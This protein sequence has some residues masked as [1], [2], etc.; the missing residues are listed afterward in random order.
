MIERIQ[1]INHMNVRV[2]MLSL[3]RYLYIFVNPK[4]LSNLK[5]HENIHKIEKPY[6]C[7]DCGKSFITLQNK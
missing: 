3:L 6:M 5:R 7:D 2:V 4:K 1:E